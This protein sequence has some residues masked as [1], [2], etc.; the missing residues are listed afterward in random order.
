MIY[1]YEIFTTMRF[2]LPLLFLFLEI[3]WNYV[4]VLTTY[5]FLRNINIMTVSASISRRNITQAK[6]LIGML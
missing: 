6:S 4:I 1:Y 5:I 3:Y 2:L